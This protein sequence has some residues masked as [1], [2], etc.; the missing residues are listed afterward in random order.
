MDKLT[1]KIAQEL[2]VDMIPN[3]IWKTVAQE[4]GPI[5]L[6][7]MLSIINGDD[8]YI[9]KPDRFLV[10]ARDKIIRKEFNGYNHEELARKYD[11]TTA[12]IRRLCGREQIAEQIGLFDRTET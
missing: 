6:I 2:T 9:P 3:G 4:I 12:Y 1:E 8:I 7:R 5:N 10:P 11:L